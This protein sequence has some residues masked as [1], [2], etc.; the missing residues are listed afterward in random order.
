MKRT[1]SNLVHSTSSLGELLFSAIP[2]LV[3]KTMRSFNSINHI[4][5]QLPIVDEWKES[6]PWDFLV[7]YPLMTM[8]S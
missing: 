4:L 6:F 5:N 3:L 8:Q 7:Q 1:D 2:G